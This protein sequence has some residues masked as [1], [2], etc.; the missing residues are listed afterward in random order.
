MRVQM[1][2]Y[3]TLFIMTASFIAISQSCVYDAYVID[4]TKNILRLRIPNG[5]P[6]Q[7]AGTDEDGVGCEG[8]GSSMLIWDLVV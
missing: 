4:D 8:E 7:T 6:S 1:N 5:I 3:P 2:H